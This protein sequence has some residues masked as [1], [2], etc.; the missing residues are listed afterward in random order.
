[1]FAGIG[2]T[3]VNLAAHLIHHVVGEANAALGSR[4]RPLLMVGEAG[5]ARLF[6]GLEVQTTLDP[7]EQPFLFDH[8]IDGTPVLPGVM[9]IEGFAEAAGLLLPDHR[10]VAVEG[11]TMVVEAAEAD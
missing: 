4:K 8:Q 7:K 11:L 6:G 5:A 10:V 1:M 2:E 9:G 3:G